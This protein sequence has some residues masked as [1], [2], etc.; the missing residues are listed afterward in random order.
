MFGSK[1]RKLEKQLM[2]EIRELAGVDS[3]PLEDAQAISKLMMAYKRGDKDLINIG[4]MATYS[5]I[6]KYPKLL[7]NWDDVMIKYHKLGLF[8]KW[9]IITW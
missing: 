8:P 6:S 2:S 3:F 1:Q 5:T 4:I 7:E 9:E